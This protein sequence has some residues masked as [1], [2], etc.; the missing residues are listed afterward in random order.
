MRFKILTEDGVQRLFPVPGV[1]ARLLTAA[2][3]LSKGWERESTVAAASPV[4]D[5]SCSRKPLVVRF[6]VSR[7]H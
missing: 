1:Y 6:N 3:R 5:L 4:R 7:G 2:W